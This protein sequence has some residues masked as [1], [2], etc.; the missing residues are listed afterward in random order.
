MRSAGRARPS[1]HKGD[2][3]DPPFAGPAAV[4]LSKNTPDLVGRIRWLARKG[5][6][7]SAGVPVAGC[8]RRQADGR[9]SYS[10]A[11][12]A[13]EVGPTILASSTTA[14]HS[15]HSAK[16]WHRIAGGAVPMDGESD[17]WFDRE[18]AGCSF[19]DDRLNKRFHKLVAHIGSAIGQSIPR[20]FCMAM[21]N[22]S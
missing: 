18:L 19:A 11:P 7:S 15:I 13:L 22:R 20:V 10:G 6:R 8:G 21:L 1:V 2:P 4:R 16:R 9:A 17:A 14:P 5:G 12:P 3:G